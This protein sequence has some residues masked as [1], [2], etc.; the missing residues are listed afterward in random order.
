MMRGVKYALWGLAILVGAVVLVVVLAL[1]SPVQTMIAK[2]VLAKVNKNMVGSL[3]FDHVHATING[4][5]TVS[6]LRLTDSTGQTLLT[7]DKLDLSVN[8][9]A[10][11]RNRVSVHHLTMEGLAVALEYDSTGTNVQR[12]LAPR[13]PAPKAPPTPGGK[14]SPWRIHIA[15]VSIQGVKTTLS[16]GDTLLFQTDQWRLNGEARYAGDSLKYAVRL[17]LPERLDLNTD[18]TLYLGNPFTPLIGHL[19]LSADTEIV[20]LLPPPLNSMGATNLTL[21]FV[22]SMD[23]LKMNADLRGSK[24]GCVSFHGAGVFPMK[25]LALRGEITFDSLTP[26]AFWSDTT[27]MMLFGNVQLSKVASKSPVNG[28]DANVHLNSSRYGRYSLASADLNIRTHDSTITLNGEI[29]TG[30]GRAQITSVVHGLLPADPEVS[31]TIRFESLNLH[32]L[33]PQIPDSLMPISGII[34]MQGTYYDPQH[35]SAD[36]NTALGPITLGSYS[37][38]SFIVRGNIRGQIFRLDTLRIMRDSLRMGLSASGKVGGVIQYAMAAVIP[39]LHDLQKIL[40]HTIPLS[41]TL[42]GSL[43]FNLAGTGD[44]TGNKPKHF[45]ASGDLRLDSAVYGADTV[46]YAEVHLN[47][48]DMDS[49][50]VHGDFIVRGLKAA[51]QSADSILLT[52]NGTPTDMSATVQLWARSDT[53]GLYADFDLKRSPSHFELTIDS[54]KGHYADITFAMEGKNSVSLTGKRLDVTGLTIASNVGVL[55][56]QGTLQRGGQED[57]SL[58][59][60]GLRTDRLAKLFKLSPMQSVTNLRVQ[61][62]GP[63]NDLTGDISLEADSIVMNGQPVADEF[64]LHATVDARRTTLAGQMNWLRDTTLIFDAELPVRVSI[65]KGLTFSKT[66]PIKG[67]L[68]LLQ[69]RLDKFNRYLPNEMQVGGLISADMTLN[70]TMAQPQWQGVFAIQ[71]GSYHDSREGIRYTEIAVNGAVDGDTLRIPSF[72]ITSKGRLTGSGWAVMAVPLPSELHLDANA[73]RFQA[74]NSSTMRIQMSGPMAVNGSLSHLDATGNLRIDEALYRLTASATKQVEPI[75]VNTEIAR[76]GGDTTRQIFLPATIYH[77]MSHRISLYIPGNTWIKGQGMNI[78]LS[79]NL[80]IDKQSNETMP[81]ISGEIDV[82]RGTVTFYGHQFQVQGDQQ[83]FIRFDGPADNPAIDITA[84]DPR[85]ADRGIDVTVRVYGTLKRMQLA[86]A[87][88]SS[89]D[90]SMTPSEVAQA[91][92]GLN[93]NGTGSGQSQS[94]TEQGSSNSSTAGTIENAATGAATG[95]LAGLIGGAAGLDVFQFQPGDQ[96]GL[97]SLTSGSLQVGTYLTERL[98]VQVVQPIQATIQAE[99]VSVEYR[100][101]RWLNLRVQQ[102]GSGESAAD[103]L[104]RVDWR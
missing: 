79:G 23:S 37:V 53:I 47:R 92:T 66:D 18:G 30:H 5:L 68:Q 74:L 39:S 11:R 51:G 58:E 62:L 56:A 71:K 76:L 7:L 70:G 46:R 65:A 96:G 61:I 1:T 82:D 40:P 12:A 102:I 81:T 29:D 28:W 17:L 14:P 10:I 89:S 91:L 20:A 15:D 73:D 19:S 26:G 2:H 69:Q 21:S 27:G 35:F 104:M 93:L 50:A 59:L 4:D 31:T 87:G 3:A 8:P 97:N 45:T 55:R 16:K 83:S 100:L 49:L 103:L 63:D 34:S 32:R 25:T 60:S 101:F 42:G 86:L 77:S 94:S 24:F 75:D 72:T 38:D 9:L 78:A 88:K 6:G 99:Q 57:F 64:M 13:H 98:F 95:S 90:S 41:D 43:V 80:Q 48:F 84:T 22:S 67:H 54:V 85:L 52:A 44:L 36:F 33:L